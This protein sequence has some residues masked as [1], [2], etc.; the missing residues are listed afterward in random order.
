[1][2]GR[3]S[4]ATQGEGSSSA[5]YTGSFPPVSSRRARRSCARRR[6]LTARN[7]TATARAP[8]AQTTSQNS[9]PAAVPAG[10]TGASATTLAR[11]AAEPGPSPETQ[12]FPPV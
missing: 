1:M 4:P 6:R 2:A 5:T 7:H 10:V 12:D 8:A 3:N 11:S 9:R